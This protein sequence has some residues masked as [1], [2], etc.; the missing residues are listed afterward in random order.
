VIVCAVTLPPPLRLALRA[1]EAAD[2]LGVSRDYFDEHVAA[3]L[4]WI[5]RG[6]LKLVSVRELEDW[7]ARSSARTLE[8]R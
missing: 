3:E 4:R 8:G 1:D 6:R 2:A 7:L 5:R